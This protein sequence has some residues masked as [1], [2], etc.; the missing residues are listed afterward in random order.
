MNGAVLAVSGA[1][2]AGVIYTKYSR[3]N[4]TVDVE[5]VEAVDPPNREEVEA[6]D[7]PN[8]EEEEAVDPPNREEEEE[9]DEPDIYKDG[10]RVVRE[11]LKIKAPKF[12]SVK[13]ITKPII[14]PITKITAK[15]ENIP[16]GISK[17]VSGVTRKITKG[18]TVVEKKVTGEIK[19]GTKSITKAF[20]PI[21]KRVAQGVL[22]ILNFP[23]CFLWYALS[24]F[25]YMLY[26]P[27][28]FL[29][30]IFGVK[31]YEKMAF[32]GLNKIDK[33]FHNMTGI[34]LFQFSDQIQSD[35]YFKKKKS[36]KSMFDFGGDQKGSS[37]DLDDESVDDS[38]VLGYLL[39]IGLLC[40][41]IGI[42]LVS[43]Q[44]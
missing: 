40:V 25:G 22:F 6:V 20:D 44:R 5:E 24:V 42:P 23:K 11:G 17:E 12:P 36:P 32:N 27:V 39:L 3:D 10:K 37:F 35:C 16:K 14:K 41:G 4:E 13:D 29:V 21:V 38:S 19:N 26:A 28:D 18:I 15:V 43:Y 33:M 8:R 7:P 1:V 34:Y 2:L 9:D 30:W 31:A